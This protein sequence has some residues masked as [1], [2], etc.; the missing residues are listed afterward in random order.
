MAKLNVFSASY[1]SN[2]YA[3]YCI[4]SVKAQTVCPDRHFYIDDGST[5]N[6]RSELQPYIDNPTVHPSLF[7][8]LTSERFYKLRNLYN[9]VQTLDDDEI[10]CVLDGDDWLATPDALEKIQKAY[11]DSAIDYVYTNWVYS[12]NGESGISRSIPDLN[13][14]PYTGA[15]ITSAMSTFR[16][17]VFKEI[18]ESN[19]LRRDG[20]WFTMAC[21]QAYVLPILWYLRKRDGDYGAVKFIDEEL[22]TYQ[23]LHNPS[24]LRH[25]EENTARAEDA[26]KSSEFIR[27]RGFLEQ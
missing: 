20:N 4:E 3:K 24:K 21:D 6:T 27:T 18:S 19:F 16:A 7:I 14:N 11:E 8:T 10:V 13:W 2:V 9:F 23:F 26:A 15:W 17:G 25:G 12:H 5:D 1:N 22:Y